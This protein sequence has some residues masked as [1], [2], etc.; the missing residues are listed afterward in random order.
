MTE[1]YFQIMIRIKDSFIPMIKEK[2]DLG[3]G[4]EVD[5]VD[6]YLGSGGDSGKTEKIT[7]S[8]RTTLHEFIEKEGALFKLTQE[9]LS[10][11]DRDGKV[12]QDENLVKI[13]KHRE[14]FKQ[15]GVEV[16]IDHVHDLGT[17]LEIQGKDQAG[18]EGICRKL[19]FTASQYIDHPYDW[20]KR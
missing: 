12:K 2:L 18:V 8:G 4:T 14:L 6:Y 16:A 3:D 5:E 13:E 11:A 7:V 20:L 17:F 10:A 19:G 9:H 15:D 1:T